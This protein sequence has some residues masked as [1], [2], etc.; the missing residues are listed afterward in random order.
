[1]YQQLEARWSIAKYSVTRHETK[2]RIVNNIPV[3]SL[4]YKAIYFLEYIVLDIHVTWSIDYANNNK[5]I[6]KNIFS[7]AK[8]KLWGDEKYYY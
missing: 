2:I 6:P 3:R 7:E 5:N 1:M 4:A 8:K